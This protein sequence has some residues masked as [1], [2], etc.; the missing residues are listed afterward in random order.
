MISII[1]KNKG[2]IF[3]ILYCNSVVEALRFY[4]VYFCTHC[5]AR[6]APAARFRRVRVHL[7][8]R[9]SP[10]CFKAGLKEGPLLRNA[11]A[12]V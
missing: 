2:K 1:N 6:S 10:G 7:E 12:A 11:S 8:V 9:P 4:F 5:A 3:F